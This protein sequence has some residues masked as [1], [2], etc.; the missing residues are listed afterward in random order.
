[1]RTLTLQPSE[2]DQL[3]LAFETGERL[4]GRRSAFVNVDTGIPIAGRALDRTL[5]G[6][7]IAPVDIT[8]SGSYRPHGG[9]PDILLPWSITRSVAAGVDTSSLGSI[10]HAMAREQIKAPKGQ[11]PPE[12]YVTEITLTQFKPIGA[13]PPIPKARRIFRERTSRVG[14]IIF[15]DRATGRFA[16]RSDWNDAVQSRKSRSK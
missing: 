5:K 15:R 7:G 1:M 6:F 16:S 2:P 9:A 13:A 14:Q 4:S 3:P 12:I 8:L 11:T 10:A